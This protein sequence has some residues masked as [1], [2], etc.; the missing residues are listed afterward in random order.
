MKEMSATLLR[1]PGGV[2]SSEAA[3][4]ALFFSASTGHYKAGHAEVSGKTND[5]EG[6]AAFHALLR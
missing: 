1:N 6:K 5:D 2:P 3:H 4:V